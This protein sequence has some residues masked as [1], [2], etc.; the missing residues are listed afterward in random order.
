MSFP[1]LIHISHS[2][3]FARK[4]IAY[5]ATHTQKLLSWVTANKLCFQDALG[6]QPENIYVTP[7]CEHLRLVIVL[8]D[9]PCKSTGKKYSIDNLMA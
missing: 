3:Q 4:Q 2:I 5:L 1:Y 9:Q 7:V 6:R 8:Y